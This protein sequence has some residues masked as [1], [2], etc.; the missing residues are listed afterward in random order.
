MA[1]K[2]RNAQTKDVDAI[3]AV[4][5]ASWRETYRGL[6]ADELLDDLRHD[7]RSR[8]WKN[9]IA[10]N[11]QYPM[12]AQFV[13]DMDGDIVGFGSCGPGRSKECLEAGFS[14]EISTLYVLA[15][16]QNKGIGSA[17]FHLLARH[18]EDIG[19]IG[20]SLW[21]L[22]TN[23]RA[24]NFYERHDGIVFSERTDDHRG[25]T[26]TEIAYSW[27]DLKLIQAHSTEGCA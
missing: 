17:L 7:D 5:I 4:H 1:F 11:A 27:R 6:L 16:Q 18:L 22:D 13:A 26:T 20:A 21:V 2:I 23:M 15:A 25:S 19:A 10:S 3:A 14:G 24:R 9:I 8:L 12:S